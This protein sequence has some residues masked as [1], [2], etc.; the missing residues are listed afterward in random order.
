MGD[1]TVNWVLHSRDSL[2]M[3]REKLLLGRINTPIQI[4]VSGQDKTVCPD[5]QK[6]ALKFLPN[7]VGLYYKEARHEIWME[8]DEIRGPWLKNMLHI[9]NTT[10]DTKLKPVRVSKKLP[11]YK[12]PGNDR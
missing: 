11:I 3:L 10:F 12:K 7:A 5:A 1:P 2:G 8:R 4:A 9:I 6:R